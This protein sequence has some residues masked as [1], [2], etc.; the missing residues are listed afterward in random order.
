MRFLPLGDRQWIRHSCTSD[1]TVFVIFFFVQF[2]KLIV[3]FMKLGDWAGGS[4]C[5]ERWR[6]TVVIVAKLQTG[7]VER[8]FQGT[9]QE[10][11]QSREEKRE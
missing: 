6:C 7:A 10:I 2:L 1:E 11:L 5:F 3:I 9:Q 4:T 8:S